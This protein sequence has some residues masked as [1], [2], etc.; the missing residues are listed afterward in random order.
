VCTLVC[1]FVC[2]LFKGALFVICKCFI[3]ALC[4]LYV[5]FVFAL[6]EHAR[7]AEKQCHQSDQL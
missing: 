5:C 6:C 4:S 7:P 1:V 3:S 2:V